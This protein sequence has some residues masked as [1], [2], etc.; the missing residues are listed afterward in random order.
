MLISFRDIENYVHD[1]FDKNHNLFYVIN[2]NNS[3]DIVKNITEFDK[4]TFQWLGIHVVINYK[5]FVIYKNDTLRLSSEITS[6]QYEDMKIIDL[7]YVEEYGEHLFEDFK[8][9]S[10][11]VH[12]P[13]EDNGI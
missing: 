1:V 3:K 2:K 13:K 12:N 4:K 9:N 6:E 10:D 8:L 7:N 11:I 5:P